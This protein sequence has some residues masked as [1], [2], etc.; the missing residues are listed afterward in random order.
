MRGDASTPADTSAL[1]PIRGHQGMDPKTGGCAGDQQSGRPPELVDVP[2]ADGGSEVEDAVLQA[3]SAGETDAVL[4]LHGKCR[5]PEQVCSKA[6]L[7][8]ASNG[9]LE[10]LRALVQHCNAD[11]EHVSENGWTAPMY[12]ARN[13]HTETVVALVQEFGCHADSATSVG[14]TAIMYAASH[15]HT[16]TALALVLECGADARRRDAQGFDAIM[17]ASVAG[18]RAMA[19]LLKDTPPRVTTPSPPEPRP[20]LD[21]Q[22]DFCDFDISAAAAHDI[23]DVPSQKRKEHS[24]CSSGGAQDRKRGSDP[25]VPFDQRKR[26]GGGRRVITSHLPRKV[27]APPTLRP[28]LES[29]ELVISPRHFLLDSPRNSPRTHAGFRATV[30]AAYRFS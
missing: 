10:T 22:R 2:E 17:Y 5:H 25:H 8:A 24:R 3:A 29:I 23:A 14:R 13:G 21:L 16:D 11:V 30:P 7:M 15:G 19:E 26:A 1:R 28:I 20:A 12:A 6:L 4:A 18:H 27:S 9:R